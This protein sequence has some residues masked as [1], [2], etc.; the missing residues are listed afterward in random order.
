MD[1]K[2]LNDFLNFRS[3]VSFSVIKYLYVIGV[4][5][6][7]LGFIIS[8]ISIPFLRVDFFTK[9]IFFPIASIVYFIIN[10]IWRLTCENIILMFSIHEILSKQ[11]KENANSSHKIGF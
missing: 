1:K 4:V 9:V 2:T 3:L 7:G 10:V 11:L 8:I 6:I 5:L